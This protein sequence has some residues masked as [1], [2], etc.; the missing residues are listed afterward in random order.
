M[1][2]VQIKS[3]RQAQWRNQNCIP[4]IVRHAPTPLSYFHPQRLK[5]QG[6]RDYNTQPITW[7]IPTPLN[8]YMKPIP[9]ER[10]TKYP[11]LYK[12]YP[13]SFI[14]SLLPHCSTRTPNSADTALETGSD[15]LLTSRNTFPNDPICY[16]ANSGCYDN[17]LDDNITGRKTAHKYFNKRNPAAEGVDFHAPI[18]SDDEVNQVMSG[19]ARSRPHP[20]VK[21]NYS[22]SRYT[23]Y[24]SRAKRM[25]SRALSQYC[26]GSEKSE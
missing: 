22:I 19:M 16:T 21:A 12:Q 14:P 23:R 20:L 9:S 18:N 11:R 24:R 26:K 3:Q 15:T 10:I 7:Q 4:S 8:S 25:I 1:N 6:H 17:T 2:T 13:G 5:R